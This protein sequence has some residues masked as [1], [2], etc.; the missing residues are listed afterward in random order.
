MSQGISSDEERHVLV[1]WLASLGVSVSASIT[2][3]ELPLLRVLALVAIGLVTYGG[4]LFLQ[5]WL[6]PVLAGDADRRVSDMR[7]RGRRVPPEGS[8]DSV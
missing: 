7:D 3:V 5:V 1:R 2:F 4:L 8:E 6:R